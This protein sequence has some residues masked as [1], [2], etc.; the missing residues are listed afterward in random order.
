MRGCPGW[1]AHEQ[2]FIQEVNPG[3]SGLGSGWDMGQGWK[4]CV[5]ESLITTDNQNFILLETAIP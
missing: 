3:S 5:R 1:V 2:W 4:G